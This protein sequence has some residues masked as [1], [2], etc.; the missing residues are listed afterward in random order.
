MMVPDII[1]PL[2]EFISQVI[3]IFG[4]LMVIYGV[5][6]TIYRV[7]R[8]EV[9]HEKRFHKYEHTKRFLIQKIIFGL[10]FFVAADLI[11]LTIVVSISEIFNIALIVAI[12]TVLSWS[13][14]REVHLHKE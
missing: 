4:I 5:T 11:L 6:R 3:T 8:I 9:F 1:V 10:D 2:M 14:S 12:R 13:L 7:I